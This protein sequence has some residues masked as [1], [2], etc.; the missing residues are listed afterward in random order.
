MMGSLAR[1]QKSSESIVNK[2][3]GLARCIRL[4]EETVVAGLGRNK[5]TP[6]ENLYDAIGVVRECFDLSKSASRSKRKVSVSRVT[7]SIKSAEQYIR[8]CVFEL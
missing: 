4:Q 5:S 6:E 1:S 8:L 7:A 3:Y 2:C